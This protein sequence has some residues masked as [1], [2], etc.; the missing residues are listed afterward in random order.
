MMRPISKRKRSPVTS[1]DTKKSIK[2]IKLFAA[3]PFLIDLH[4]YS[5]MRIIRS[6]SAFNKV[7]KPII[8]ID[9]EP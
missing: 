8:L 5:S 2:Q 7:A 4:C 3:W 1:K 6:G 9:S